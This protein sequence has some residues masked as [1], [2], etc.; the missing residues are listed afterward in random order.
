[1]WWSE[2]TQHLQENVTSSR[3][4]EGQYPKIG[5]FKKWKFSFPTL[6]NSMSTSFSKKLVTVGDY[7]NDKTPGQC[8]SLTEKLNFIF[9]ISLFSGIAVRKAFNRRMQQNKSDCF[10][11]CRIQHLTGLLQELWQLAWI[12]PLGRKVSWTQLRENHTEGG[13]PHSPHGT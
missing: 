13:C 1:M 6:N 5:E 2:L 3:C 8:M 10:S 9:F 12:S 11:L 4:S 7:K